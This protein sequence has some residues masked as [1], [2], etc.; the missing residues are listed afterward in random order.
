MFSTYI[1][2]VRIRGYTRLLY[3]LPFTLMTLR[4]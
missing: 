1:V 3:C 2:Q 4:Y